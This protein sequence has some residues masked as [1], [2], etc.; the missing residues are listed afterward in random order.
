MRLPPLIFALLALACLTGCNTFDRR[1]Q[2][3]ADVF[4]TLSPETRERLKN[5]SI[6]V[7]DTPDMV[8][9][10]LGKPDETQSA[11]TAAGETIT[12]IYNRYWQEYQGEAYAGVRPRTVT[13][14]KTGAVSIFYE[15]VRQPVYANRQQPYLRI[16]F[17]TGKVTSIERARD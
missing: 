6:L 15:P 12:W 17:A 16:A 4:A 11:T 13:N 10:A 14:P 3:K 7:G 8:F 2:Q 5:K 9:I 1:A